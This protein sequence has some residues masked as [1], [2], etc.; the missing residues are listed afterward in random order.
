VQNQRA[1]T[2]GTISR[3]FRG[4]RAKNR[5]WLELFLNAQGLRVEYEETEG[6]FSKKS[7]ADRFLS[8]LTPGRTD[9][10][11]R[12]PIRR[13]SGGGREG[14]RR[15]GS[16]ACGARGGAPPDFTE[17]GARGSIRGAARSGRTISACLVHLVTQGRVLGCG[18]PRVAAGATWRGGTSPAQGVRAAKVAHGYSSVPKRKRG[19]SRSSPSFGLKRKAGAACLVTK[20]GSG[21]GA[22]LVE[23]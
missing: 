21:G 1:W 19:R 2:A 22:E 14:P 7:S 13:L 16:P 23:E 12:I 10:G 18:T 9:L 20:T 17:I 3:K 5:T 6:L 11:R 4:L 8:W 15:R